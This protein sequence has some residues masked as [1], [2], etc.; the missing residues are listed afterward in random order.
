M[1]KAWPCVTP[2]T[3]ITCRRYTLEDVRH[4]DQL[5]MFKHF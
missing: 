2:A 1:K 3:D 4:R 5:W